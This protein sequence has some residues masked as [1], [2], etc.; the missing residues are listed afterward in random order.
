LQLRETLPTLDAGD[1]AEVVADRVV[2]AAEAVA[3][4]VRIGLAAIERRVAVDAEAEVVVVATVLAESKARN[5]NS[6]ER[7]WNTRE[8][9]LRRD[10]RD[11]ETDSRATRHIDA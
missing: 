7:A 8:T 10:V 5:G 6:L 2:L 11:S 3:A 4:G 1:R 9:D